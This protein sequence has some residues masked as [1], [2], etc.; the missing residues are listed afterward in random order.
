MKTKQKTIFTCQS[1][2]YQS[3]RWLGRCPDCSTWNSLV[4]EFNSAP[5]VSKAGPDDSRITFEKEPP[6]ALHTVS[7]VGEER[8]ATGIVE[9]DRVLGGGIVPG[10]VTLVGGDPG[11]G[12]STLLLQASD[13]IGRAKKILYVSGEESIKQ[14]KLRAERL[15]CVSENLFI[16]NETNLDSILDYVNK[17]KPDFIIVRGQFQHTL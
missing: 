1:C 3:L 15:G 9:L 11:I 14:T 7:S 16:V 8:F 6:Q 13:S 17:M 5:P 4:E 2:G 12:K 10:S